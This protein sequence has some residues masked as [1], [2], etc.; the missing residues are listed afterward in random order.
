MNIP[1]NFLGSKRTSEFPYELNKNRKEKNEELY[2]QKLKEKKKKK[3]KD[4]KAN[5]NKE[6]N[7]KIIYLNYLM[8][9]LRKKE[10]I[11]L[12]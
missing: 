1:Q 6:P 5:K 4:K 11:I 12:N 3:K 10:I 8:M 9:N 2:K 7:K